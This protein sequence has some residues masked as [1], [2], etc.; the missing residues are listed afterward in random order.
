[1]GVGNLGVIDFTARIRRWSRHVVMRL[2]VS[3]IGLT[4][5]VFQNVPA[6]N[7]S[8]SWYSSIFFLSTVVLSCAAVCLGP[9]I[10]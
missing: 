5:F 7:W 2:T 9:N 8:F 4:V 6:D 1:M 10:E 3:N